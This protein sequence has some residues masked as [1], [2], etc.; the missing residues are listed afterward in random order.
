[1]ATRWLDILR[2]CEDGDL[3][4]ALVRMAHRASAMHRQEISAGGV[5]PV[6]HTDEDCTRRPAR[7][8]DSSVLR[9][10]R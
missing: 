10:D 6:R 9:P 4:A 2:R 3:G 7:R 5:T 1:M 8:F